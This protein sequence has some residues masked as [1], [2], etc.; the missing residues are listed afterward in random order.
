MLRYTNKLPKILVGVAKFSPQVVSA[1]LRCQGRASACTTSTAGNNTDNS[2]NGEPAQ[3]AKLATQWIHKFSLLSKM[4]VDAH[5]HAGGI[6]PWL[7]ATTTAT[8]LLQHQFRV[9]MHGGNG[10]RI[11]NAIA[12]GNQQS[13]P[14]TKK[15]HQQRMEAKYPLPHNIHQRILGAVGNNSNNNNNN[16]NNHK[17]TTYLSTCRRRSRTSNGSCAIHIAEDDDARTGTTT[18]RTARK[19]TTSRTTNANRN[20]TTTRTTR[21]TTRTKRRTEFCSKS[22]SSG[23]W[24][25]L[26]VTTTTLLVSCWTIQTTSAVSVS[27]SDSDSVSL[28]NGRYETSTDVTRYLNLAEDVAKM[29]EAENFETKLDLYKLGLTTRDTPNIV[30]LQ[31]LSLTA[32]DEMRDNPLYHMFRYAFWDLGFNREG[33]DD[34]FFDGAPVELYADTVVQDLFELDIPEIEADAALVLNVWMASVNGVFAALSHCNKAHDAAAGIKALD[35]TVALWIGAGQEDGSNEKGHL[36]YNLAENA[37]ERFDQDIGET[38]VNT[39]VMDGFT[40]MQR[41]LTGGACDASSSADRYAALRATAR[42][43]VGMM[44]VPLVQN[45]IHHTLNIENEGG[46]DMVELYALGI[47]PRVATCDPHAYDTLLSLAVINDLDPSDANEAITV[48]QS[49]YSCLGFGCRDVGSYMGGAYIDRDVL[50]IDVFLKYGAT[51]LALDWYTHGWNSDVTLQTLARNRFVPKLDASEHPYHAL[52]SEYYGGTDSVHDRITNLL[53]NVLAIANNG[54]NMNNGNDNDNGGAASPEQ[55]RSAVTGVLEFV[56]LFVAVADSLKYAAVQCS[57]G[58]TELARKYADAGAVFYIGS[59]EGAAAGL[60]NTDHRFHYGYGYGYGKTLFSFAQDLCTSFGTCNDGNGYDIDDNGNDID[61]DNDNDGNDNTNTSGNGSAAIN[62]LVI[63][64]LNSVASHIDAS[65]CEKVSELIEDTILPAISVPLLQGVLKY[66][67]SN[68]NLSLGTT[69]GD[70]ATGD[71]LARGILPLVNSVAPKNAAVLRDQMQYEYQLAASNAKPVPEGF[72]AV[73]DALR[74]ETLSL[75]GVDC[76]AIGILESERI[77]GAMC[78]GDVGDGQLL[79]LRDVPHSTPTPLGFGRYNFSDHDA[80]VR[81]ASF[82]M[83]VRGM[84]HAEST[85]DASLLYREGSNNDAPLLVVEQQQQQQQQQSNNNNNNNNNLFGSRSSTTPSLGSLS[86]AAHEPMKNDPLFNVYKYAL[87]QD[88]DFETESGETFAYANDI[89]LEAL[90]KGDD[91]KLAAESTV[92]LHVFMVI[93]HKVYNAA[94]ICDD[95]TGASASASPV[96]EIDSAVALWLGEKQGEGK[97]EDGWMMYSIGQS[98]QKFFGYDE[99][100]APVNTRLMELFSQAQTAAKGCGNNNDNNNDNGNDNSSGSSSSERR[101]SHDASKLRYVSQEIVRSLTEPLIK[102]LLFHMVTNSKNMVELYSVAT[103]P[104]CAACDPEAFGALQDALFSGYNHERSL[105]DT[106]L[107]HLATFLR[108]QEMT[109]ASIQTG[110]GADESLTDLTTRLCK[111]LGED[112]DSDRPLAG[113]IPQNFVKEEARL[114]LDAFEMYIMMRTRAYDAAKDVYTFGHNSRSHDGS[115]LASFA[116]A[117]ATSNKEGEDPIDY[118]VDEIISNTIAKTFELA[119]ATREESAEIVRRVMQSMVSRNAVLRQMQ[120]SVEECTKGD[121]DKARKEWDKAVAYFVG[122]MEGRLA[123]GENDRHGV[124]MYALGNEFCGDFG[125]CEASGEAKI[126]QEIMFNFASGRDSMVDG[127]CDHMKIMVSDFITP[128]LYVPLIQGVISSAIKIGN[129]PTNGEL[130]ATLHILTR[131]LVPHIERVNPNSASVLMEA[132]GSFPSLS[133]TPVVSKILGAFQNVLDDLGVQCQSIGNPTGYTLCEADKT[134][135]RPED[136]PT[137]L[138]DNLYVT[139]TYVQDRANIAMDIKDMAEA[140]SEGNIELAQLLYRKGKNSVKYDQNGK[141]ISTRTIK[142]FSTTSTNDMLDEPEFNLYLYTLKDQLYADTLVEDAMQNSKTGSP[143]VATEAATVLNIWMEIVHLM[144]ETLKACKDKELRDDNSVFLMDAAVAYWIGDG[145]V[146]GDGDNG[147]LLYA[148]SERYGEAFKLDNAGQTRTN[149]NILRLFNEAKNEVSLPNA[150]SEGQTT[151]KRLRGIVNRLISQMAI[152]LIQG[153]ITNLRSNDRERVKIYAHA[154]VPLVAGCREN[155]FESLKEK[156]LSNKEYNVV[157]VEPII[158]M[159]REAYGCLGLKCDDIGVHTAE[160]KDGAPECKDPAFDSE[161]AGYRP[162]SDVRDVSTTGRIAPYNHNH[163]SQILYLKIIILS[164]SLLQYSRL[165]LDIREMDVLLQMKA[166]NAVD[167]LYTHGKHARGA[168]GVVASIGQLATTKHRSIVPQFE[169]FA[170]YYS[171]DTYADDIIRGALDPVQ[172]NWTEEQRRTVVIKGS[173][174]LVMYFAALQNA[175]EAVSQCSTQGIDQ[176]GA[177]EVWDQAAAILIGSLQATNSVTDEGYMLYGLA[178]DYCV[179]FGTCLNQTTN[180]YINDE[181]V[182][183]LYTGRGAA[184]SNSCRALEKTAYEL[185]SLLLIPIIQGALSTS[186]TLSNGEDLK[187]RAE[188]YIYSRALVPLVRRRDA[189]SD[190]ELY[191]GN[192]APSDKKH[193]ASKVYAALATAYP[194]MD[195]ECED[196][197]DANGIDTCSGVV[198]VSDYLWIIILTSILLPLACCCGYVT[199]NFLPRKKHVDEPDN[200]Y[201]PKYEMNHSMD[202][203]EKAFS[204]NREALSRSYDDA[205]EDYEVLNRRYIDSRAKK[206]DSIVDQ[207]ADEYDSDRLEEVE[208]LTSKTSGDII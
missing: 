30:T 183:L 7:E 185:S 92:V 91:S 133:T 73:A 103:I 53:T 25:W 70:L 156:L 118:S 5:Q 37:G 166:Y 169:S 100:E 81:D 51:D 119:T 151:Y 145:Q 146:A 20:T 189:A 19:S 135:N 59:M 107:D 175:Y 194:K 182:S 197:G 80:A 188:A 68:Q 14:P 79:Q 76:S 140:L 122:S 48:L 75:L 85:E 11:R 55:L 134:E 139:T 165:D 78:E 60:T 192:Q 125:S 31:S 99:G 84:F 172:V 186:R 150:C 195:V 159:I 86:T 102:S 110:P 115:T 137:N 43:L 1:N 34:G 67:S 116:T 15:H 44:T 202:L 71:A 50:Q 49:V 41:A 153:L 6:E 128:K 162:S 191:L 114:D 161:L 113:Y 144:H 17:G 174:V 111:R 18:R 154:F 16:N 13:R 207:F 138:A 93:A 208:A 152:P 94:R 26:V 121:V 143:E 158:G 33:E 69:S 126:T 57:S 109:C 52:Y 180:S 193:T 66:A 89:T 63:Q 163:C 24:W 106:V 120:S 179:E 62:E 58:S 39:L 136:T 28:L 36:L 204:S 56:V 40:E 101:S 98:V 141:L 90:G 23:W 61:N 130:V 176:S 29:N 178:E 97:F 10:I 54:N 12:I 42:W 21:T 38:T 157:E 155:L 177:S 206:I 205:D 198:Y 129:H 27:D 35:R 168:G 170:Q 105:D 147:H 96:S 160:T 87:Y 3:I 9:T 82:A 108:C 47:L 77:A 142:E 181:V 72:R 167:E 64:S 32:K 131:A 124:W 45:F 203:L 83:D 148:L 149:T 88:K 95:T 8:P 132:F 22:S 187:Q 123:G 164:S 112:P 74:G 46:S 171:T 2:C 200:Y 190:L 184:L 117:T 201:N 104:Q 199:L 65:K 196:I 173:Q 4:N 127:E